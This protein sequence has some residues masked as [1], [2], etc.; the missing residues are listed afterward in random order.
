[1]VALAWLSCFVATVLLVNEWRRR[2]FWQKQHD[3][4]LKRYLEQ[5]DQHH[6]FVMALFDDPPGPPRSD[7]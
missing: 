7:N 3:D 6:H 5:G 4:L 2:C 1:M